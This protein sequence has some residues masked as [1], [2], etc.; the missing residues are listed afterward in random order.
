[1]RALRRADL[2]AIAVSAILPKVER[3]GPLGTSSPVLPL[4][5]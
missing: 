2:H 3:L 4:S 5:E 1:M